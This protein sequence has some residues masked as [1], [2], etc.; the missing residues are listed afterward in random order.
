MKFEGRN[1]EDLSPKF[2]VKTGGILKLLII[3]ELQNRCIF[4]EIVKIFY[5]F[6][7]VIKV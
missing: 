7:S 1:L 5:C 3:N 6:P 2:A 4:A